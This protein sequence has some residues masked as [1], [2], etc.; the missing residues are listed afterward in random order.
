MKTGVVSRDGFLRIGG[1]LPMIQHSVSALLP[2]KVYRPVDK[3]LHKFVV[4][5]GSHFSRQNLELRH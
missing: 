5:R 2:S 3:V 1:D 4:L